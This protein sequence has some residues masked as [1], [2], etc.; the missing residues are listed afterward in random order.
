[1]TTITPSP[2][3]AKICKLLRLVRMRLEEGW[4]EEPDAVRALL[5]HGD[6]WMLLCF[7]LDRVDGEYERVELESVGMLDQ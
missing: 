2:V 3:E 6:P 4:Y 7:L 1:M 5:A